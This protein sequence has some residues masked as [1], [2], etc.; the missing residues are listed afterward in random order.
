VG[1]WAAVPNEEQL[2]RCRVLPAGWRRGPGKAIIA[3]PRK[4]LGAIYHTLKNNR[5]FEDFP[6]LI[7]NSA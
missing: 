7:I 4:F 6:R 5:A 3:L 2:R 1:D